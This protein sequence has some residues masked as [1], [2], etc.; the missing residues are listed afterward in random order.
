MTNAAVTETHSYDQILKSSALI[1]GST[2]VDIG[3]GIIRTKVMAVLLGPA[4]LGLMGLYT[5]I[6]ELAVSVA[7]MGVSSSGVRQIA[8]AVGT[9]DEVRISQTVAVLQR[10]SRLL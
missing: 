1:G 6:G 4:G 10:T 9:G 2:M 5:S 3:I 7:G 8:E